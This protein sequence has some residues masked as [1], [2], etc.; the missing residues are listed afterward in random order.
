MNLVEPKHKMILLK[1]NQFSGSSVLET[2]VK[3]KKSQRLRKDR[4]YAKIT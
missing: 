4:I 3:T 2:T 1:K